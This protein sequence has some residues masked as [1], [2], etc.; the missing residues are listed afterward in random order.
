MSF[1]SLPILK[2]LCGCRDECRGSSGFGGETLTHTDMEP[3]RA[4]HLGFKGFFALSP[5]SLET[6][7]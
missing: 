4:G 6:S 1:N 2:Y 7:Y 3:S 5:E